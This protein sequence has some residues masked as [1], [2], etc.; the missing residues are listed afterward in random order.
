MYPP[1]GL[2]AAVPFVPV[3]MCFQS[4]RGV[5]ISGRLEF[6]Y[7]FILLKTT[8]QNA[9]QELLMNEFMWSKQQ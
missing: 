8:G 1:E 6:E 5:Q 9:L 7:I 2:T 3:I 4:M